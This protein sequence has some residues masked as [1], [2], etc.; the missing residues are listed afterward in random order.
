MSAVIGQNLSKSPDRT[1]NGKFAIPSLE[2]GNILGQMGGF[3]GRN[4]IAFDS[5]SFFWNLE[6]GVSAKK[7]PK[8]LILAKN[9]SFLQRWYGKFAVLYSI[10]G[11]RKILAK[12]YWHGSLLYKDG[13]KYGCYWILV[14]FLENGSKLGK[15]LYGNVSPKNFQN[16]VQPVDRYVR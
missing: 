13:S 4:R 9:F 1:Q 10:R 3:G 12:N 6:R 16:A 8:G 7:P 2:K 5:H 14:I 15:M 11:L